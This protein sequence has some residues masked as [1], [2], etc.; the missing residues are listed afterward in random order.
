MS[1]GEMAL[2]QRRSKL[3]NDTAPAMLRCSYSSGHHCSTRLVS[4][5]TQT[6]LQAI[7][8]TIIQRTVPAL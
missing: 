8:R 1:E 7:R 5:E 3:A 6:L 4:W 2:P